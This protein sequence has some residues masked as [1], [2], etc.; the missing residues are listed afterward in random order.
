MRFSLVI[1]KHDVKLLYGGTYAINVKYDYHG[2][3]ISFFTGKV[4]RF[5]VQYRDHLYTNFFHNPN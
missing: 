1:R 5:V 4:S 3:L 2:P